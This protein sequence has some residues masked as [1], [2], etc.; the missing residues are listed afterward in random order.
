VTSDS[1]RRNFLAAG[2]APQAG[3]PAKAEPRTRVLG[4][5]GLKVATVGFGC[6]ITSDSSVIARAL[7]MGVN[8]FDTSRDYQGGNNERMV[9][10]AL[11]ARRKNV[12]L[13]TKTDG[14]TTKDALAE[15]DTS[16]RELKTDH[17]DIWYLHEKGRAADLTDDLF[18]A[19][20]TAKKSGKTRF[21]GV[22][23]HGG[24]R[25]VIPAAIKSGQFDVLL[26]SYN[27]A[28]GTS[29]DDLIAA[30]VKAGMGVVAMKVMAGSFRLPGITDQARA[31]VKRPGAHLAALK[32]AVRNPNVATTI[33]GITGADQLEENVKAMSVPF[34]PADNK[35]LSAQLD[36][37]RPLYCRMCGNCAGACPKGVPVSDVLRYL[38][39]AEGY[40][41]FSLAR[42]RFLRLPAEVRDV[43][44]A[45]CRTCAIECPNGVRVAERLIRAQ[46]ILA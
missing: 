44:C 40:G 9:G 6:M 5:T 2:L 19:L 36:T 37:I 20:Q 35:V 22:S 3:V 32:W 16:L 12:V 14:L 8:Y 21:T 34:V 26:T 30:T 1:S 31:A 29:I 45:D 24:H 43:R 39:Y 23:V 4:K 18:K 7:D 46:E 38:S 17:V 25:D 33:P 42:E 27:F 41:Q 28:M 13:S 11:G 15:L 10:A